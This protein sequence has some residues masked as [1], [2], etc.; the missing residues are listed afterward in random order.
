[1]YVMIQNLYIHSNSKED[2]IQEA[3]TK[4]NVAFVDRVRQSKVQ[5][6]ERETDTIFNHLEISYL[7]DF[8]NN[9]NFSFI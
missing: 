4:D 2:V 9:I 5:P 7:Q 1:M 6:L 3:E 8:K